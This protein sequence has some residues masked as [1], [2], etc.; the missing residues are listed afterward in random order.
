[1]TLLKRERDTHTD[2]QAHV[3]T[4]Q[5]PLEET[6]VKPQSEEKRLCI[7]DISGTHNFSHVMSESLCRGGRRGAGH[8]KAGSRQE[9]T[10]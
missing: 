6:D 7:C 3:S 2:T 4:T 1:M 5:E 9:Q 10:A 8:S